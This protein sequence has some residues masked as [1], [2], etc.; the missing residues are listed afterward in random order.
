M[1]DKRPS[2]TFS[3]YSGTDDL[4]EDFAP[5]R[6]SKAAGASSKKREK[7]DAGRR[8]STLLKVL[9]VLLFVG[10]LGSGWQFREPAAA[11]A[12]QYTGM[13][14]EFPELRLPSMP[15]MEGPFFNQPIRTVRIDTAVRRISEQE[16]RGMMAP[17]LDGGFFSL[18]VQALKRELESHPWVEQASVRRVWPDALSVSVHEQRPIARWGDRQVLNQNSEL[19]TPGDFADAVNLPQLMGPKDSEERVMRHYH[20]FTQLLQGTGLRIRVLSLSVR[21]AWELETDAGI[22]LNIGREQV[23]ERL[24]RFALLYERK[25]HEQAAEIAAVDLRYSNGLAIRKGEPVL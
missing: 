25:L 15:A 4:P 2:M 14:L 3:A 1:S 19:F 5:G 17:Y 23:T 11:W 8:S 24:Q 21:G 6:Q 20:Q 16:V 9:T 7:V 12:G 18:D 22:T 13:E 10:L